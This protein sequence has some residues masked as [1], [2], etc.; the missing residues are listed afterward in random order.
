MSL[1]ID[2][3]V[4]D[5]IVYTTNITHNLSEMAQACG[6]YWACWHPRD[7]SCK[8]AR[9]ITPMLKTG[10]FLLR[11]YPDFYKLFESPNKWGMYDDFFSWL[12]TF[13]DACNKYPEAKL[14]VST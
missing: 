4:D 9:H 6:V 10:L 7:I 5:E 8:K 13:T 2:L 14:E 12:E 3:I 1:D 11:E